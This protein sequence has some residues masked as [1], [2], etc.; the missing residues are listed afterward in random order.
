MPE[1]RKPTPP[2]RHVRRQRPVR[3]YPTRDREGDAAGNGSEEMETM[4]D[5]ETD[6]SD[7][8]AERIQKLSRQLA[9]IVVVIH[10]K[11]D[12]KA[13]FSR[14][15]HGTRKFDLVGRLYERKFTAEEKHPELKHLEDETYFSKTDL[16]DA[17]RRELCLQKTR[18]MIASVPYQEALSSMVRQNRDEIRDTLVRKLDH[19][20]GIRDDE[21]DRA[22][23]GQ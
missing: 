13:A 3:Q 5:K 8:L 20:L 22:D 18:E 11:T 21:N 15:W 16:E 2:L 1:R 10:D 17:V 6:A 4:S 9:A 12:V 14:H 7:L 19:M 23:S